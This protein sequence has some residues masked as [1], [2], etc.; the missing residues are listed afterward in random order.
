MQIWRDRC[1][2]HRGGP[3]DKIVGLSD[4]RPFYCY[5]LSKNAFLPLY[6]SISNNIHRPVNRL[7]PDSHIWGLYNY[8]FCAW[9]VDSST[10]FPTYNPLKPRSSNLSRSHCHTCVRRIFWLSLYIFQPIT[11]TITLRLTVF[12][13]CDC[14]RS[15]L[16]LYAT[17]SVRQREPDGL[18]FI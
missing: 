16:L 12:E 2:Q 7:W 11:Y 3:T 13:L 5:L 17:T 10:S 4:K 8:Y 1:H 15:K 6:S 14:R 9:G 18:V